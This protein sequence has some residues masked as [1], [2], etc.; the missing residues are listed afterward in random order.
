MRKLL[1]K[2]S[3]TPE[4]WLTT[5]K[6]R[7]SYYVYFLGQNIIY[8]MVVTFLTTY[9]L[10][11]GV[12]PVK[13]GSVML[14]VKIWDAVNDAIFGCIFD[15]IKFKNNK[16]FIPWLKISLPIIPLS[17]ALLYMIPSGAAE[18]VKLIWFAIFYLL[19][20]T[21]YTLCD[22][23]IYGIVTAM[24]DNLD[25][26]TS[27]LSYKSIW[28]GAGSAIATVVPTII[29]GQQVGMSFGVAAV[30]VSV[31]AFV[32]MIPMCKNG[33]ERFTNTESAEEQFTVKMMLKYLFSNK[34]LLIYYAGFFFQS[35]FNVMTSMNLL[36]SYYLFGDE[37][38]SLLVGALAVAP[39]LVSS[40]LVPKMV[41]KIGKRRLF[42][43][44]NWVAVVLGTISWICGYENVILFI[45][46]TVLRA[47]PLGIQ[48]VMLFMFTPDC[49]EYG[50]FKTGI[51][52]KGITFAIQTFMAKITGA[53]SSALGM[54]LLGFFK[55]KDVVAESFQDLKEQNVQQSE[56][57]LDGL[58]F[59]YVM[60]PTIGIIISGIIWH[61]YRLNDADVKIMIDCNNGKIT[62]KGAL[63]KIKIRKKL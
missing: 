56:F 42:I 16:K 35:G 43:I 34:Y 27:L 20:D 19:W 28:S 15:K 23:P 30:I 17:T 62:R 6:E 53:M 2:L 41:E 10:F 50:K 4:S 60:V 52:A 7:K 5:N 32:T 22:V 9:L 61:F 3:Y 48:G 1:N 39:M 25:E 44:S 13:S 37:R 38:F 45:I 33:K 21:A 29:T 26:R 55:W 46:L 54:F 47:I 36:A 59:I 8:S 14:I 12:D 40:L 31:I 51:D 58:W 49:A 24:T 11:Q 63:K 18:S 57:T